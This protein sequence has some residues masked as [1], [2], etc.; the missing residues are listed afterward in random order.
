MAGYAAKPRIRMG[1]ALGQKQ[2]MDPTVRINKIL[3]AGFNVFELR[4]RK[5][6]PYNKTI[7]GF[8]DVDVQIIRSLTHEVRYSTKIRAGSMLSFEPDE[9]FIL[10]AFLPDTEKNR[11]LLAKQ[12]YSCEWSI[13]QLITP[14]GNIPSTQIQNEINAIAKALGVP[15]PIPITPMDLRIKGKRNRANDV[16][17]ALNDKEKTELKDLLSGK[18]SKATPKV[19]LQSTGQPAPKVLTTVPAPGQIRQPTQF[20]GEDVQQPPGQVDPQAPANP[21][22]PAQS[23]PSMTKEQATEAVYKENLALVQFLEKKSPTGWKSTKEY[24]EIIVPKINELMA[25]QAAPQGE[26][27]GQTGGTA[28]GAPADLTGQLSGA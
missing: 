27:A 22:E 4:H 3:E 12:I 21:Q 25:A 15:K 14:T 2:V 20:P 13:V 10:T 23:P 17:A 26:N 16:F 1:Q 5:S 8:D 6:S 28:A 18:V 19:N 9:E 11:R 24:R 7:M